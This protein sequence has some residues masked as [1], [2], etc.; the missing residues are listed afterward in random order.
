M[1]KQVDIEKGRIRVNG[2]PTGQDTD[3]LAQLL[4]DLVDM[5]DPHVN[6][7]LQRH[8]VEFQHE[9]GSVVRPQS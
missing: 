7:V 1:D 9:D 3:H 4:W 5:F 6:A 8:G 2:R